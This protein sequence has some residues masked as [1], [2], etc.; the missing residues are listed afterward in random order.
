MVGAATCTLPCCAACSHTVGGHAPRF[1]SMLMPAQADC[2]LRK[3]QAAPPAEEIQL[4]G[5]DAD[6]GPQLRLREQ[7]GVPAAACERDGRPGEE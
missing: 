7:Q 1:C 4:G 3:P 2:N 6:G 5:L